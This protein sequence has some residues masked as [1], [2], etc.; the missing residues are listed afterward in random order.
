[1]ASILFTLNTHFRTCSYYP[2]YFIH[3]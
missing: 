3:Y 2:R 1:M